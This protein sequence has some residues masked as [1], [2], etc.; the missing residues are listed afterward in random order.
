[1]VVLDFDAAPRAATRE[2]E[3]WTKLRADA[4]F[5]VIIAAYVAFA[6]ALSHV[7]HQGGVDSLDLY[8]PVWFAPAIC[9]TVVLGTFHVLAKLVSAKHPQ[10]RAALNLQ[11]K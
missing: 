9:G 8:I 3:L 10:A 4:L 11:L 1:M 2:V 6:L 5:Y 7:F